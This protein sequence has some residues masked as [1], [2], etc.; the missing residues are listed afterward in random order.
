MRWTGR[1]RRQGGWS[2]IELV[3]SIA[4]LAILFA[5]ALPP[6]TRYRTRQYANQAAQMLAADCRH[7]SAE[8]LRREGPVAIIIATNE[9]QIY[10][11]DATP[12]KNPVL[13][14][15]DQVST[16]N[17]GNASI[18]GHGGGNLL[19]FGASGWVQTSGSPATNLMA[20]SEVVSGNTYNYYQID[21]S[22]GDSG[23]YQYI[24]KVYLNGSVV[25]LNGFGNSLVN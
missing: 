20:Q 23:E 10:N 5:T 2:L 24:V 1:A 11:E 19:V 13:M 25:V 22:T 15:K 3:I 14:L 16:G 4:I 17:L 12:G 21:V 7:A 8:A 9:W 6:W 18:S